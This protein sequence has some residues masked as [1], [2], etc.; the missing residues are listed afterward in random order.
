M[1]LGCTEIDLRGEYPLRFQ[2]EQTAHRATDGS[3]RLPPVIL[4]PGVAALVTP[5]QR[6]GD[7]PNRLYRC[8]SLNGT[9]D[10]TGK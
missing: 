9:Y 4:S 6:S 2:L 7:L 10:L 1:G 8:L 5:R 3:Q